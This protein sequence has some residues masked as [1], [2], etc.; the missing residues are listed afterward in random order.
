MPI[1]FTLSVTLAI[2]WTVHVTPKS[3]SI[4]IPGVTARVT[5]ESDVVV[6]AGITMLSGLSPRWNEK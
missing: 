2:P 5:T 1:L 6:M 3:F 4:Y